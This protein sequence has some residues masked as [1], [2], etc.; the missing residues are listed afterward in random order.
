MS[1]SAAGVFPLETYRVPEDYRFM[2]SHGRV[3]ALGEGKNGKMLHFSVE[4]NVA[5][6]LSI[7]KLDPI[8]QLL[9]YQNENLTRKP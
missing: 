9:N 3:S 8:L 6:L 2:K 5:F 4:K 1:T 7:L